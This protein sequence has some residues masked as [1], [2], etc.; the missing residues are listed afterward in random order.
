MSDNYK[1]IELHLKEGEKEIH[2]R[3]G[4]LPAI[5]V[6]QPVG[7][8]AT[9][10]APGIFFKVR[11]QDVVAEKSIIT[12][13]YEQQFIKLDCDPSVRLSPKITGKLEANPVIAS[14]GI[15][16]QKKYTVK[17]LI[18]FLK[19]NSFYFNDKDACMAIV[20]NL[21]KFKADV[22]IKIEASDDNRGNKKNLDETSVTTD[23]PLDF[24]LK[25]PL[26]KGQPDFSFKAEVCFEVRDGGITLWL[27][28]VELAAAFLNVRKGIIDAEVAKFA[29]LVVIEVI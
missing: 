4:A 28:S 7:Y 14:F 6:Q 16:T 15:N 23:V 12:Y 22:Q 21:Q 1:N 24:T 3:E 25:F 5:E 17:D 20:A 13:S 26:F 18:S 19:L 11:A 2:M 29:G 8:N 10:S 9:I 27:E